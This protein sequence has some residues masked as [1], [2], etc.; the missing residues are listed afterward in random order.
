LNQSTIAI[1]F[2]LIA[3]TARA[4][5][6]YELLMVSSDGENPRQIPYCLH[7]RGNLCHVCGN[8]PEI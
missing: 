4:T 7:Q 1:I 3:M 5:P 6:P 8:M 2:L